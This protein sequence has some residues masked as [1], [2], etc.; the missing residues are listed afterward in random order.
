MQPS[1]GL[2]AAQIVGAAEPANDGGAMDAGDAVPVGS[3]TGVEQGPGHNPQSDAAPDVEHGDGTAVA[4]GNAA[5]GAAD[6]TGSD[7]TPPGPEITAEQLAQLRAQAEASEQFRLDAQKALAELSQAS[8]DFCRRDGNIDPLH[9]FVNM[10]VLIARIMAL[11]ELA[12]MHGFSA[13]AHNMLLAKHCQAFKE[14]LSRPKLVGPGG[15]LL[16]PN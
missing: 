16:K 14:N 13:D 10:N 15:S 3:D 4:P 7:A 11:S 8:V 5:G 6:A 2:T 9:L 1:N 12:M